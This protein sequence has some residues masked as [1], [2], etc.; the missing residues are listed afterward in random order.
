MRLGKGVLAWSG[1]G[2]ASRV[3]PAEVSREGKRFAAAEQKEG[4]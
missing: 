4:V 3:G 2:E 1:E